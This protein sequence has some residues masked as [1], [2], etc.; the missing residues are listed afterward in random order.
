LIDKPLE[1][2]SFQVVNKLRWAIRQ[3]FD[4]K[5]IKVGHAGTLDPLASGLLIL[6][7]GKFTKRIDTFQAQEKTYTGSFTLGATRP[8]Y[9]METEIDCEYPIDHISEADL[10]RVRLSFCGEIDQV[11]PIFSALKKDGKKLYE[12]AR[13]GKT[14]EIPSR[15]ITIFEFKLT[16]VDL[17]V[18]RFEVKCSKGTYIR[19]L[20]H[21]F[22]KA[23]SSGAYLSELRRTEIGDFK[24]A[25]AESIEEF[26]KFEN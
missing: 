24:V 4:I 21:D 15:K 18:V 22:G 2:T 11:P 20:A 9:D 26:L 13:E 23:L 12:L 19:S 7:T 25:D 3:E 16:S 6:C 10:E 1:W 5:K 8:S 14:T 17:P